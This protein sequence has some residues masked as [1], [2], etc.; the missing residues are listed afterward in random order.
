LENAR[1]FVYSKGMHDVVDR[2]SLEMAR[3]VAARLRADPSL[4]E[5]ARGNL[6]RWK[7]R[8][9]ESPGLLRNYREWEGILKRPLDE[10]IA[11]LCA[12]TEEGQRLRQ[13]SPFTGVL[14]KEEVL[15]IKKEFRKREA[16]GA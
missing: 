2:V 9:A 12:D 11:I 14:A 7:Q 13:N 15:G 3:R 1:V 6:E 5:A 4:L 10:I 8:N 16:A